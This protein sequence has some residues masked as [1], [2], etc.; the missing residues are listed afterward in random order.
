MSGPMET[1]AP[2]VTGMGVRQIKLDG[3]LVI[4]D[5]GAREAGEGRRDG[6]REEK[7]KKKHSA[8]ILSTITLR[9]PST[10]P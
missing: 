7:R 5:R 2:V 1:R 8:P 6:E 10:T 4:G 9:A 3:Y